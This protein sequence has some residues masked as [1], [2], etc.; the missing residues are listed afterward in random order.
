VNKVKNKNLYRKRYASLIREEF[1]L[2]DKLRQAG[3]KLTQLEK[4]KNQHEVAE[5]LVI[6]TRP[7][8]WKGNKK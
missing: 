2:H 6:E 8:N 4:L 1:Y 7:K 3:G 5:A